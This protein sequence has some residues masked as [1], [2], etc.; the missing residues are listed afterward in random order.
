MKVAQIYERKT[1]ET[2][3]KL[4]VILEPTL[5][6]MIGALVGFIAFSIIVPIYSAVGNVGGG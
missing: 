2:A 5:L 3:E 6:L 4:P 1:E